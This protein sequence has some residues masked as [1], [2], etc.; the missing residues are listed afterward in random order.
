MKPV[1]AGASPVDHPKC[2]RSSTVEH[3]P[4]TGE[5][6]GAAPVVR[7]IIPCSLVVKLSA[8]NRISQV[9]ALPWEP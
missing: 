1:V 6:A 9:R 5:V 7:A 3:S 8:V 4:V 2:E